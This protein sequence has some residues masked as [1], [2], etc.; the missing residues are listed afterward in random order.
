MM[1]MLMILVERKLHVTLSLLACRQ[2]GVT[3]G[4]RM[5]EVRNRSRERGVKDKY[6]YNINTIQIQQYEDMVEARGGRGVKDK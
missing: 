3:G 5:V 2:S 6:K 4:G 1:M